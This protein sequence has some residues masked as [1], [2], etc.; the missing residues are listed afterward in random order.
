MADYINRQAAIE[1]LAAMQGL[2]TS[3]AALIQNSKIWQ[4]IKN[5]PSADVELV[6]HGRWINGNG[7]TRCSVCGSPIPIRKVMRDGEVIWENHS[8]INYCPNCGAKM[9][10]EKDESL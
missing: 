6:K 5:L 2:C 9:N 4:Q 7:R 3:E 8:P 10:G 1:I